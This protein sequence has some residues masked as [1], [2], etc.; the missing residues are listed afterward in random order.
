MSEQIIQ[1]MKDTLNTEK[2][3]DETRETY[4]KLAQRGTLLYLSILDLSKID[5][6]YKYSL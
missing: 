5:I 2:E 6:M 4:R 3:I 1:K